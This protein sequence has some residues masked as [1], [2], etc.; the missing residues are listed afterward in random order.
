MGDTDWVDVRRKK[1]DS[2]YEDRTQ[3]ISH[4]IFVTNFP[5]NITYRDLWKACNL[6]GTVVDVFIPRK[7]SQAVPKIGDLLQ[8]SL[9]SPFQIESLF[10]VRINFGILAFIMSFM[11]SSDTCY[12]TSLRLGSEKNAASQTLDGVDVMGERLSQEVLEV[13]KQKPNLGKFSFVE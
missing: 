2:S 13:I 9:L 12:V 11:L 10:I 8:S 6:Y 1:S 7:K 4:S 3:R 5:D